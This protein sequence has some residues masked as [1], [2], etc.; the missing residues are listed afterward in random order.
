[1][2]TG[3]VDGVLFDL[4]GTLLD[5]AP[6]L[7]GALNRLLSELKHAPVDYPAARA[8]AST[9]AGGLLRMALPD[10]GDEE[11]QQLTPRYLSL[12]TARI[13]EETVLFPGMEALL[14]GIEQSGRCWGVVTNKP[15]A[16]T[17]PL[18]KALDLFD[19]CACVISGDTLPHRKPRPE[20]LWLG[21]ET[22]SL[23]AEAAMYVG[24][25]DRDIEA[26]RAAGMTTV[27]VTYGYIL[28]NEDPANWDTDYLIHRPEELLNHLP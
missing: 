23:T 22:A 10:L 3:R 24:D 9:G 2:T 15:A 17:E 27:G 5:T 28:P 14:E 7:V 6:D 19:R 18:L 25:A 12:Y 21:L 4:D 13:A 8:Y 26:G 11:I 16:L 1:M 20:P